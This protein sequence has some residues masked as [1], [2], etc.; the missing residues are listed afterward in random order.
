MENEYKSKHEGLEKCNEKANFP[1][2]LEKKTF[3]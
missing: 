2:A 3:S 1:L